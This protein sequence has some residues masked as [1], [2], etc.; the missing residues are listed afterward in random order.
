MEI[1]RFPRAGAMLRALPLLDGP[2]PTPA[3]DAYRVESGG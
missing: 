2:A 3:Q 1:H